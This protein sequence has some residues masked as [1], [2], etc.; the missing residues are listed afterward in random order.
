MAFKL[1]L[2]L[3]RRVKLGSPTRRPTQ[4]SI[5]INNPTPLKPYQNKPMKNTFLTLAVSCL[6]SLSANAAVLSGPVIN[7]ANGNTYYRLDLATWGDAEAEAV[8]LGGHL[9]TIND[10]AENAWIYSNFVAPNQDVWTWIGLNDIAN[11]GTYIWSSGETPGYF[12]WGSGEPNNSGNED[13][14]H[15]WTGGTWNDL[16]VTSRNYGVVEVPASRG[17]PDGGSGI[18]MLSLALGACACIKRLVKAS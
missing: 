7:P 15:M 6:V 11:E 12:N 8:T 14:V 17:V 2:S 16:A 13:G 1:L 18:W 9:A 3:Q 10:A 4:Q 5:Q